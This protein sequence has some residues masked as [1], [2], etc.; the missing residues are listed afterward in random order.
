M[1]KAGRAL[2]E[3]VAT[4]ETL[5]SNSPVEIRSPDFIMGKTTHTPR[6]VDVS[7]RTRV[8]SAAP[9]RCGSPDRWLGG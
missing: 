9:I 4:L 6:E 7:L 5:L 2:E 3:L 8:G 1:A